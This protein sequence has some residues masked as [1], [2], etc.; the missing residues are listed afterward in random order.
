MYEFLRPILETPSGKLTFLGHVVDQLSVLWN[1]MV[2]YQ[3]WIFVG[4]IIICAVVLFYMKLRTRHRNIR[5]LWIFI[6]FFLTKRQML[7]PLIWTFAQREDAFEEEVLKELLQ[8]RR[9]CRSKSLK[10][11]PSER[12]GLERK[13]SHILY[14]YFT[15]LEEKG[16]IRSGS[17]FSKIVED[18]E[19][20]DAKLVEL[21]AL[22]NLEAKRWNQATS[23]FVI[24]GLMRFWGMKRFDLFES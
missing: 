6:L 16:K 1:M 15:M 23:F 10:Y 17:K 2:E 22:Y 18:L 14:Q 3:M 20:I 21:Q 19:F 24:R 12:L 9:D 4:T 11:T 13:V 8:I 7:I 5:K